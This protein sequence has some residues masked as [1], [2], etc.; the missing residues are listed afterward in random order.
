VSFI[1]LIE[2]GGHKKFLTKHI[3]QVFVVSIRIILVL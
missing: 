2:D 3:L 1:R